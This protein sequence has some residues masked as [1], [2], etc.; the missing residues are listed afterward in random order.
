MSVTIFT[1]FRDTSTLAIKGTVHC[2][3]VV[4]GRNPSW[5]HPTSLP[6]DKATAENY[7]GLLCSYQG[8]DSSV[9]G[10]SE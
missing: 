7:I 5:C 1:I 4:T 10:F 8:L 2:S 3:A 9:S 6:K